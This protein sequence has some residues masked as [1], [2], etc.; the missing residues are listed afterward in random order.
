MITERQQRHARLTYLAIWDGRNG[1]VLDCYPEELTDHRRD[2]GKQVIGEFA[3]GDE[4]F[5]AV[6]AKMTADCA[7]LNAREE[8]RGD[9]Q[10]AGAQSLPSP[11]SVRPANTATSKG[12]RAKRACMP[13]SM[14]ATCT[15]ASRG[16]SRVLQPSTAMYALTPQARD[17][18]SASSIA[19]PWR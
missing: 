2:Y 17:G 10:R 5:S 7:A 11:V 4:A 14:R 18:C 6:K 13:P 16:W 8:E 1:Y 12:C 15:R 9:R 19:A 3:T